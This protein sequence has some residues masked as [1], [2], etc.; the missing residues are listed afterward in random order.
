[1]HLKVAPD[2]P[3]CLF[4][5]LI[6]SKSSMNCI[7]IPFSFVSSPLNKYYFPALERL[8]IA[9]IIYLV[10]PIV[11]IVVFFPP[12]ASTTNFLQVWAY[13]L[14]LLRCLKLAY[15]KILDRLAKCSF[16]FKCSR[17]FGEKILKICIFRDIFESFFKD[18]SFDGSFEINKFSIIL[19]FIA[20]EGILKIMNKGRLFRI[21]NM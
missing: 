10:G 9:L 5:A 18:F 16:K 7:I 6:S 11:I 19:V 17:D 14:E 20:V 1:M 15:V 13:I 8:F 21:C 4:I 12:I 2:Y 3:V